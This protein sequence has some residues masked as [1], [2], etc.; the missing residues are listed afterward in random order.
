MWAHTLTGPGRL[1]AT[2]V[3][4]LTAA[5][6]RPGEILARFEAGAI[7]GSD[8]PSFLGVENQLVPGSHGQPG[9]SLHEVV[10]EV[11]A[12]ESEA[13][14]VGARVVGWAERHRGLAEYFVARADAVLELD[15]SLS[16][17]QATVIQ[18]LCTVL[19]ALDRLGDVA[20]RRAAV[21]GQ[22][23]IGLLF[24]HGLKSR[25]AA[26][27]TGVD[28]VDRRAVAGDFGVDESIWDSSS[29]WAPS[30]GGAP[31]PEIVIEA[32]GHQAG[33][34]NDAVE[35]VAPGG[36]VL[37]F[38]VPDET[39]YAFA[40]MQFFRRNAT[41]IGGVTEDR[42]RSLAQ[43]RDYL[44]RHPGLLEPYITDVF[45]VTEAQAAFELAVQPAA[46]RLK[47]VLELAA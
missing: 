30:L 2:E 17:A 36:T 19:Y 46:G 26:H 43:A 10:G 18:P 34:L 12:T 13:V 29:R 7:C 41:L 25:G 21:I 33:T 11:V 38:G 23:P 9:Y 28:R 3:D 45:P 44:Q 22:G 37:A 5:D 47:I 16:P 4:D 20:G 31:R 14:A 6:L 8:L 1:A 40:F 35:A 27:V 42:T 32:V 24:S 15:D 39:H